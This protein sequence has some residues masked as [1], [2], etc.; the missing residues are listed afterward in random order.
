MKTYQIPFTG[1]KRQYSNLRE[2]ILDTVDSVLS[3]GQ[4]MNG[5]WTGEFERWLAA[6]NGVRYAV[7]CHSGT[8]ALEILAAYLFQKSVEHYVNPTALVPAISFPATASAF[9]KTGWDLYFVDVD[10]DGCLDVAKIPEEVDYH[11][12]VLVGL[13]GTS[14]LEKYVHQSVWTQWMFSQVDIVEDAA[15]HWLSDD[16][17]RI[18]NSAVS[19]DP[20]KNLANHGNG[21]AVLTNDIELAEFA[22]AWTTHG[23]PK[24]NTPC[25]NSRMSELDCATLMIKT[26][27]IDGW[28]QRRLQI[29]NY[30]QKHFANLPVRCLI[31]KSN[32]DTHACQKFVIETD[33]RNQIKQRL[34]Q[35]GIETKIHYER[36]LHEIEAFSS[37]A[38][39][40]YLTC[41]SSLARRVLSLPIY[42]ELTDAEVEYIKCQVVDCV[43][44]AHS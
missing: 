28:Q 9:A 14:V 41:A 22:R 34:E 1:V 43:S 10:S 24:H 2:E 37:F 4:H 17:T 35:A 19:F 21:G 27:H 26:Y 42:P 25:T 12:V 36:P 30:W 6:R 5:P 13:Y 20:T 8:Q 3:S 15:Q 18:A 23:K 29:A 33:Y 38:N 40:G 39:P 32:R 11:S 44:A 7:T 31:N 16:C